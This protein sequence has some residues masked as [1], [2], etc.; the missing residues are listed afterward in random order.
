MARVHFL[1]PWH[2]LVAVALCVSIHIHM[3]MEDELVNAVHAM[4]PFGATMRRR[5]PLCYCCHG[6]FECAC[7]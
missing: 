3:Y 1:R 7:V 6:E 2:N 5:N 4:S